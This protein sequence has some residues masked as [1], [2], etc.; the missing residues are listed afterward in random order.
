MAGLP[1]RLLRGTAPPGEPAASRVPNARPTLRYR[2]LFLSDL[3]LGSTGCKADA[4]LRFLRT[5]R[6]D[7]IYLIGD[8][9]DLWMQGG[10][11]AWPAAQT[12]VLRHLLARAQSGTDVHYIVGNHD[13][14]LSALAGISLGAVHITR[15]VIH[16]TADGR[17]VLVT[18]GDEYDAFSIRF[19]WVA[20]LATRLYHHVTILNQLL[21]RLLVAVGARPVSLCRWVRQRAKGLSLRVAEYE[22]ALAREAAERGCSAVICGHVHAPRVAD[23]EGVTY[24]NT[25]DWVE[26]C[27]AV[28]E[29]EDGSLEL[30]DGCVAPLPARTTGR[31][32]E[33]EAPRCVLRSSPTHTTR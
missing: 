30:L 12:R 20:R 29:N 14:V 31:R 32:S 4:L 21:D 5:H 24:L 27:S 15:Q 23:L 3:H 26:N 25:G 8:T 33:E 16:Q 11:K 1:L 2:S 9:L 28:V 17:R 7:R 6:A 18:H 10:A 13:G 19:E 22:R